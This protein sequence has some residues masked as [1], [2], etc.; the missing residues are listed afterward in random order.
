MNAFNT[1]AADWQTVKIHSRECSFVIALSSF[2]LSILSAFRWISYVTREPYSLDHSH[3]KTTFIEENVSMT[4]IGISFELLSYRYF[5]LN[6][7]FR[8][9]SSVSVSVGTIL[10]IDEHFFSK[11]DSP[12]SMIYLRKLLTRRELPWRMF[13]SRT[14]RLSKF[15]PSIV[16]RDTLDIER[17][18]FYVETINDSRLEYDLDDFV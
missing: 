10:R 2:C 4:L 9:L 17:C 1:F 11:R 8:D 16:L 13:N 6:E 18:K 5:R 7:S 3:N 15:M 12:I 14:T